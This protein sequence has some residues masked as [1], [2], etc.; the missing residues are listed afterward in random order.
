[1]YT[2]NFRRPYSIMTTGAKVNWCRQDRRDTVGGWTSSLCAKKMVLKKPHALNKGG[3]QHPNFEYINTIKKWNKNTLWWLLLFYR[4][5]PVFFSL[6][7]LYCVLTQKSHKCLV[8]S[9]TSDSN[10]L[11]YLTSLFRYHNFTI[12]IFYYRATSLSFT[13]AQPHRL[14]KVIHILSLPLL[15]FLFWPVVSAAG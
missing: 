7:R 12:A 11:W 1:M 2:E 5:S 3:I 15:P 10:S 9:L 13:T 14:L 6:D 4:L 8:P